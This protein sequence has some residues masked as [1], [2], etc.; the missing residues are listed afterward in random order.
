MAYKPGQSGN[1]SGR[2]I[3]YREYLRELIGKRGEKAFDIIWAIAK[4]TRTSKQWMSAE[5]GPVEVEQ[6]PSIKEQM[7]AALALAEHLNGKPV[8]A[9]DLEHS[10]AVSFTLKTNVK[11][12]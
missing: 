4:G 5:G 2:P 8:Q 12:D 6:L 10:G 7:G 9:M 1:P 11:G 3:A